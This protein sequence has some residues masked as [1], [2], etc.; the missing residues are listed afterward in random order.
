MTDLHRG[1]PDQQWLGQNVVER[2]IEDF[3][4]LH[5]KTGP[6]DL[7]LFTGDLTNRGNQAQ[8]TE[9][10]ALLTRLRTWIADHQGGRQPILL[11]V[12]GNHDLQRPPDDDEGLG[13]LKG[14]AAAKQKTL[15]EKPDSVVRNTISS[16][17]SDYSTWWARQ[18]AIGEQQPN[19]IVDYREGLLPGDFSATIV[20]GLGCRLGILGLNTAFL[21]LT[22]A[23]YERRLA[24]HARQFHAACG[25]DGPAWAS[26]HNAC[27]LLTHHPAEWLD[28]DSQQH[29][30]GEITDHGRFALH[31]CGHLHEPRGGLTAL[32]F[33]QP[34]L[35]FQGRS[36]F[37][38]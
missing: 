10:D 27:L 26:E 13:Y 24:L 5:P 34:K 4:Y 23:D 25:G 31:L 28:A 7:I 35:V 8:F 37:G 32:N 36:L 20:N 17:F 2:V 15:W 9:A 30:E 21:Q 14:W 29:L 16:A 38:W 33:T 6:W 18:V 22:G 19:G 3:R 1:M 12:P 11:A